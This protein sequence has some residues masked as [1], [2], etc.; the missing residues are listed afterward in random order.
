MEF[1]KEHYKTLLYLS[2]M[3]LVIFILMSFCFFIGYKEIPLGFLLGSIISVANYQFIYLFT[4]LLLSGDEKGAR[5]RW[6]FF[7][8]LRFMLYAVGLVLALAL[9]KFNYN[10]FAWYTV[11]IAYLLLKPYLLVSESLKNKKEK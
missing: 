10:I 11:A 5:S 3:Y 9:Q 2:L 1:K 6:T 4:G 8:L 7:Y